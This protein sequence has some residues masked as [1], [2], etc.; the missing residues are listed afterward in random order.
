MRRR[1]FAVALV[2][3]ACSSKATGD[4]SSASSSGASSSGASSGASGASG[5][6]GTSGT[7]GS[8]GTC[9]TEVPVF[10]MDQNCQKEVDNACCSYEKT[11]SD[12]LDCVAIVQCVY[13]SCAL[14][15]DANCIQQ[16]AQD[17]PGGDA[18]VGGLPGCTTTRVNGAGDCTYP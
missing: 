16:C 11:C 10:P 17:H 13:T 18:D 5:A 1:L 7:S 4:G 15:R 3:V 9:T 12:D 14:P 2:L 8:S 6:S